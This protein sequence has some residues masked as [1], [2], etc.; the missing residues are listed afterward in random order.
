MPNLN[1]QLTIPN[2]KQLNHK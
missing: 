2:K 1:S